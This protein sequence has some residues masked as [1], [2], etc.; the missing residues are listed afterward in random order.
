[1]TNASSLTAALNMSVLLPRVVAAAVGAR[2]GARGFEVSLAHGVWRAEWG[3]PRLRAPCGSRL[4]AMWR[5]GEVEGGPGGGGGGGGSGA[6]G[7]LARSLGGALGASFGVSAAPLPAALAA[8]VFATDDEAG[9]P[10]I[11]ESYVPREPMCSENVEAWLQLLPCRGDAGLA[12]LLRDYSRAFSGSF[13]AL[14][15]R[16]RQVSVGSVVVGCCGE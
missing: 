5:E 16:V 14:S 15:F 12:S 13:R 3:Q 1:M 11:L 10:T 2:L 4:L 8:D 6:F 9:T 7:A